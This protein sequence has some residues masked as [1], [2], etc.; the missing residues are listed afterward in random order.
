MADRQG[1]TIYRPP[2][3]IHPA[4][5]QRRDLYGFP[6]ETPVDFFGDEGSLERVLAPPEGSIVSSGPPSPP[7]DPRQDI[8][9]PSIAHSEAFPK[10]DDPAYKPGFL[11]TLGAMGIAGLQGYLQPGAGTGAETA[12]KILEA[13]YQKALTDWQEQM[14][15]VREILGMKLRSGELRRREDKAGREQ[16]AHKRVMGSPV[17]RPTD[18]SLIKEREARARYL[19]SRAGTPAAGPLAIIRT[20]DAQGRPVTRIVPKVAGAEFAHPGA[21]EKPPSASGKALAQR[22]KTRAMAVAEKDYLK[23]IALLEKDWADEVNEETGER[24]WFHTSIARSGEEI[25]NDELLL[26]RQQV[27]DELILAKEQA[28]ESYL[29]EIEGLGFTAGEPFD[30]RGQAEGGSPTV[31]RP[32]SPVAQGEQQPYKEG[33]TVINEQTGERLVLRGGQWV[34]IQ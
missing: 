26:L 29:A 21:L 2:G 9:Q 32:A 10:R 18:P 3:M 22:T 20:V 11:R 15:Q 33:D 23:K 4:L 7:Q 8:F 31:A 6:E 28:D 12:G 19:E 14:E 27:E 1:Q 30:Y 17:F 5:R 25:S 13:P 24:K 34:P 16:E